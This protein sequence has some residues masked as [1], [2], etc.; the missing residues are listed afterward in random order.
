MCRQILKRDWGQADAGDLY[1]C[2]SPCPDLCLYR[3]WTEKKD[4]GSD[5][6]WDKDFQG[7]MHQPLIIDIVAEENW[8]KREI[9]AAFVR[10]GGGTS[11]KASRFLNGA[12]CRKPA[13][14][15]GWPSVLHRQ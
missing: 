4:K 5:K 13:L 3:H 14:F 11:N 12:S 15:R 7:L 8:E 9:P 2:L 1:L 6:D 10:R